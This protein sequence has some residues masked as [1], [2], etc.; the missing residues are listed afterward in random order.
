[1]IFLILLKILLSNPDTGTVE[2]TPIEFSSRP[3]SDSASPSYVE[4]PRGRG[5]I[6]L[7]LTSIITLILCVYTSIHLNIAAG[8]PMFTIKIPRF[9]SSLKGKPRKY[10][11]VNN[12]PNAN[13][14]YRV[15][16]KRATVYKLY[17]V[18]IA[19][20]APEF[21]LFA[22]LSQWKE[23]RALQEILREIGVKKNEAIELEEERRWLELL[24]PTLP[25][26]AERTDWSSI[27]MTSA[28]FV[29]MGGY[30]YRRGYDFKIPESDLKFPYVTLTARGFLE[31][32][33]KGVIHPGILD[34]KAITDRSKAD[35]L[36]KLL[37]CV[38]ALWMVFNVIG[39]KASGLP[40]TLIELNVIVHVMVMVIV[41]GLWW[42][43]P[44]EVNNPI[45]LNPSPEYIGKHTKML[46]ILMDH[47]R[48]RKSPVI[49]LCQEILTLHKDDLPLR[50]ISWPS[51]RQYLD[52]NIYTRRSM[53]KYKHPLLSWIRRRLSRDRGNYQNHPVS[54]ITAEEHHQRYSDI[55][56]P[57]GLN[58]N[59]FVAT[60]M[61]F[62][63][64]KE[65]GTQTIGAADLN[66]NVNGEN[67]LKGLLL[68]P[69]EVLI[70]TTKNTNE[71]RYVAA[72]R[73]RRP[74]LLT[75]HQLHMAERFLL[76]FH[77]YPSNTDNSRTRENA[78]DSWATLETRNLSP[79]GSISAWSN[80]LDLN[81]SV[82]N[83][84]L[85]S[86]GSILSLIYAGCHAT[87]WN[88][89]FPSFTERY[90]WRGACIVI[91]AA[92]PTVII[93][94]FMLLIAIAL[95]NSGSNL[96]ARIISV[97]ILICCVAVLFVVS[98]AVLLLYPLARIFII[99]ESF[100]S[101]RSLPAGA[102]ES[103]NWIDLIPHV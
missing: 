71:H 20:F 52:D 35:W 10:T 36:A 96:V 70:L 83:S 74:L 41:Y 27:S 53:F 60:E 26:A 84:T 31:L 17:W 68:H 77:A 9:K 44:F 91:A 61:D 29:I 86:G 14:P 55:S 82:H 80:N 22:A 23:A 56:F 1:M 73:Y 65:T 101:I 87:A 33:R 47:T 39:R 99:V 34:D 103:V 45:I 102:Y 24:K 76:E 100:I 85:L 69:G 6:D 50:T 48:D 49:K 51:G 37:V 63:S 78:D 66:I 89:H 3:T 8:S 57:E 93:S 25:T 16:V 7:L 90:L 95:I 46:S 97:I 18:I 12:N 28:F 30:A 15:E 94:S 62:K 32:A 42:D 11:P 64:D 21:V 19:L 75:E 2:A 40:S 38:Q 13:K 59:Y 98:F 58:W 5:T 79:E 54:I 81:F 72:T 4:K 43:K 88:S 92:G 67:C